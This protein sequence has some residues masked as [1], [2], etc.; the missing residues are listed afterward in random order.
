MLE[1]PPGETGD[2]SVDPPWGGAAELVDL[3]IS[4]SHPLILDDFNHRYF[5]KPDQ[6]LDLDL[7]SRSTDCDFRCIHDLRSTYLLSTCT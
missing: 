3:E 7:K 1:K 6:N 5:R 2:K 4:G